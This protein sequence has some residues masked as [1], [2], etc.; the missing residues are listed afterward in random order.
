MDGGGQPCVG[1]DVTDRA[2]SAAVRNLA[3][4]VGGRKRRWSLSFCGAGSGL[5]GTAKWRQRT[6]L[7]SILGP[8]QVAGEMYL[9][10]RV[11]MMAR[12]TASARLSLPFPVIHL[13][14]PPLHE[15]G[16]V[17]CFNLWSE[18]A[19][20]GYGLPGQRDAQVRLPTPTVYPPG[21]RSRSEFASRGMHDSQ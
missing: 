11:A 19:S 13:S 21:R 4:V 17:L 2:Q 6:V 9:I 20:K 12:I 8:R 14:R 5:W 16:N 15:C 10:S 18:S 1:R 7:D 3:A